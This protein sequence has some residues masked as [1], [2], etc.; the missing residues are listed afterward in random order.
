MSEIKDEEYYY[1]EAKKCQD[2]G[3]YED[4]MK[5]YEKVIEIN[6]NKGDVYINRGNIYLI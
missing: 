4:A 6:P 2:I 5:Y 1:N 3:K